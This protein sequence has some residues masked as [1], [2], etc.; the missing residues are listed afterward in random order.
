LDVLDRKRVYIFPSRAGGMFLGVVGLMLIGAINYDNAL[1][2]IL[3]FLL[4]GLV[5]TAMLH[6][7]RNLAGLA[8]A[9]VEVAPVF[10]GTPARFEFRFIDADLRPRH[11]LHLRCLRKRKGAGWWR[12][13]VE[14]TAECA[15]LDTHAAQIVM[16][17]PTDHRGW[18]V[19]GRVEISSRYPLG[20][21]RAWAYLRQ[22]ARCLV[23]P[24]PAGRLPLT[25]GRAGTGGEGSHGEGI[26]DF[27]GLRP[28]VAGDSL[29]S[30]HWKAAA[31]GEALLV[32]Q[33]RGGGGTRWLRWSDTAALADVEA[34]LSQLA[35]WIVML[36]LSGEHYGLELPHLVLEP[37]A[38]PVQRAR[39]LRALALWPH[40]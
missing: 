31:R 26:D 13:L 6:T 35:Q 9:E 3:A 18:L 5:F 34:R 16:Q 21:L 20:I 12:P 7:W 10:A 4:V 30:V 29:R 19:L 1:A 8:L 23:Y 17:V 14:G 38:G 22:N 27:A 37:D 36:D 28:Y 24:S 39:A 32:K 11:S 15:T 2:Y 25:P 40:T 33:L